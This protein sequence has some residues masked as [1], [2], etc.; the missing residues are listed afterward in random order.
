MNY[1]ER[2]PDGTGGEARGHYQ[3]LAR[4]T[5]KLH[6]EQLLEKRRESDLLFH[7]V[8]ITFAIYGE[9]GVEQL[10]PFE[11]REREA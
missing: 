1:D 11:G 9:N 10:I 3:S 5:T 7:R 2:Y 4:W 6:L 8:G